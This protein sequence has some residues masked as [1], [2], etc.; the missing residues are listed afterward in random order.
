MYFPPYNQLLRAAQNG[1]GNSTD[2]K[3]ITISRALFDFLLQTAL[4][5]A[6]FDEEAYLAANPEVKLHIERTGSITPNQHF[7]GYGYFEGRKGA[8]PKV[9]EQ[10]YLST[11]RDV[12]AA[13]ANGQVSSAREHFELVG[14]AEGRAPSQEYVDVANQWKKLLRP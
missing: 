1:N 4:A 3:H 6:D 14:A 5:T 12:A 8:L 9:D 13:V 11:Y 7:V 2:T 10:W